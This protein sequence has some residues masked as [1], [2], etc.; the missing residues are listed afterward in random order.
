MRVLPYVS[1]PAEFRPYDP[2]VEEIVQMVADNIHKI[3]RRLQVEHI[4]STSVPGCSG[5]GIVDL[6]ILYPDGFLATAREVLDELGFQKQDG[7]D[8]FPENRPMRVGCVEHNGSRYGIHAHILALDCQ[9][10]HELVWFRDRLRCDPSL[11]ERYEGRKQAII[12]AGIDESL[13]YCNAKRGF[14]ADAPKARQPA[15]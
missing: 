10:Y 5:K 12:A 14:I 7:P 6:A 2:A 4:G 1:S 8:P 13:E 9:E 15:V 11:R 3:E